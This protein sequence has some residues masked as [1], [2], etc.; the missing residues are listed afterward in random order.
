ML[1]AAARRLSDPQRSIIL[2]NDAWESTAV[3]HRLPFTWRVTRYHPANRT[4][5]GRY[6]GNAWTSI[7][8]VG[9]EF[10]DGLL[11]PGRYHEVE[12]AYLDAVRI[13][14]ADA[15]VTHLQVRDP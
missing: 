5:E 10:E 14:A 4:E 6:L 3:P 12:D 8:D 13:F 11:T 1:E 15:G 7:S 9:S 2:R